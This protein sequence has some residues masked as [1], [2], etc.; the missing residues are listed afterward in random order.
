MEEISQDL[1]NSLAKQR[2]TDEALQKVY[3]VQLFPDTC[4][5]GTHHHF[6]IS[7]VSWVILYVNFLRLLKAFEIF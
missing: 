1:Y 4:A 6:V 7:G 5:M 2:E 3:K